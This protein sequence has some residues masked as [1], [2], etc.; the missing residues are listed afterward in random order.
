MSIHRIILHQLWQYRS[1]RRY[2]RRTRQCEHGRPQPGHPDYEGE[3]CPACDTLEYGDRRC[4]ERR[5][6]QENQPMPSPVLKLYEDWL[7]ELQTMPETDEHYLAWAGRKNAREAA[8]YP[9]LAAVNSL[10]PVTAGDLLPGQIHAVSGMVGLLRRFAAET[11][12]LQRLIQSR[13]TPE[14]YA[15]LEQEAAQAQQLNYDEAYA[16]EWWRRKLRAAAPDLAQADCPHARPRAD[17]ERYGGDMHHFMAAMRQKGLEHS[18]Q[19][20]VCGWPLVLVSS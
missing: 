20:P 14:A 10:E 18:D 9:L 17:C 15:A 2:L 4:D 1:I 12:R 8:R 16:G 7:A 11:A 5:G 19:C 3:R 13:T 6:T